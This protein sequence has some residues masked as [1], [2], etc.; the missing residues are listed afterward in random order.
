MLPVRSKRLPFLIFSQTIESMKRKVARPVMIDTSIA[1][2]DN[3]QVV[4]IDAAAPLVAV[5]TVPRTI[6]A[7][8]LRVAAV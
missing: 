8:S 3:P 2:S 6:V 1:T 5:P 7:V 4:S